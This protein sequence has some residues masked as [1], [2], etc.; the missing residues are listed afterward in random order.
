L[1]SK[2]ILY[3]FRPSTKDY[4]TDDYVAWKKHTDGLT[5]FHPNAT[6]EAR[7]K[8]M[9]QLEDDREFEIRRA[10]EP[11]DE[12]EPTDEEQKYHKKIFQPARPAFR[13]DSTTRSTS[14][15]IKKRQREKSAG[16]A[17]SNKTESRTRP[18]GE[19]DSGRSHHAISS[20]R[21]ASSRIETS[22]DSKDD[23]HEPSGHIDKHADD[24][25]GRANETSDT[26]GVVSTIDIR[27]LI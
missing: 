16:N 23:R 6:D 25:T 10:A 14:G 26:E 17:E 9:K 7:D 15:E 20:T 11:S 19:S 22:S 13:N 12:K 3:P 1:D 8:F 27:Y 4:A 5:Y 24:G 21:S 2:T 18:K